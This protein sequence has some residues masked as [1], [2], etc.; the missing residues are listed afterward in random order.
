MKERPILYQRK[1]YKDIIMPFFAVPT[2]WLPCW[3]LFETLIFLRIVDYHNVSLGSEVGKLYDVHMPDEVV[4]EDICYGLIKT[5]KK[6]RI[7]NP[8]DAGGFKAFKKWS[9]KI[10]LREN[11]VIE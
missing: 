10:N 8:N 9:C 2:Y 5:L 4:S 11:N 6:L 7:Y 1:D 3:K